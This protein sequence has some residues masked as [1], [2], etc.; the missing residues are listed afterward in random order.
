MSSLDA[1]G[2]GGRVGASPAAGELIG[3]ELPPVNGGVLRGQR[4]NTVPLTWA[5]TCQPRWLTARGYKMVF[6]LFQISEKCK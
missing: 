5:P 1:R 3:D 6:D 2:R 4:G